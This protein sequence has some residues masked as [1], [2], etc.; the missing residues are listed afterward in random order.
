MRSLILS[1]FL[2]TLAFCSFGQNRIGL[3]LGAGRPLFASGTYT[4]VTLPGHDVDINLA[5]SAW[6]ARKFAHHWYW[7][8][9]TNFEQYSF[10]FSRKE[11]DAAKTGT[12]GTNV[13]HKSS[14]LL[15]GPTIDLGV[16][17]HREYLH[18]Y[19]AVELGVL[20]NSFQTT[21]EYHQTNNSTEAYYRIARTDAL[22]N[23]FICR[24]NFGL[25]QHFPIT[26]T[27]Q[28]IIQ[29]GYS[30]MPFGDL[31]R[32]S[33]TGGNGLRPGYVTLQF[34]MMHKFKDAKRTEQRN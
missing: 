22:V 32:T 27:W 11:N 12:I 14:Y 30:A 7:G 24:F 25:K 21:E 9:K 4:S 10:E 1:C 18:F 5:G 23:S 6:Y 2:L 20:L 28:A 16:G 13:K 3:E 15:F 8:V 33:V 17:K 29:E 31:S 34:G 19:G 26:K